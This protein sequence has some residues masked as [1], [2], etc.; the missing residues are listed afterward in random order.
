VKTRS[1]TY[2]ILIDVTGWPLSDL[3]LIDTNGNGFTLSVQSRAMGQVGWEL[4]GL[5]VSVAIILAEVERLHVVDSTVSKVEKEVMR[6][7]L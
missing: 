6:L 1:K 5:N 7:R 4:V 2:I 3:E